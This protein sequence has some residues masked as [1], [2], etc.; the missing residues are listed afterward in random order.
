[1]KLSLTHRLKQVSSLLAYTV[2][3]CVGWGIV[4]TNVGTLYRYR[5]QVM[6]VPI[7]WIAAVTSASWSIPARGSTISVP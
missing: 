6:F 2:V 5:A 4:V 1:M 7:V 3:S